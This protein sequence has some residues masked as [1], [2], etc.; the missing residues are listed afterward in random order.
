MTRK[1]GINMYLASQELNMSP[2]RELDTLKGNSTFAVF[3]PTDK[4]FIELQ[5]STQ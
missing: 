2:I 5:A 4:T 1:K 3:V